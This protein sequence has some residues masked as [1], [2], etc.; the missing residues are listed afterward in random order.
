MSTGIETEGSPSQVLELELGDFIKIADRANENLNHQ[1]F[2]IDYIDDTQLFLINSDTFQ[3]VKITI[4]PDG[5]MN[6]GT[7]SKITILN[8]SD[9]K[10]YARQHDLLPKTWV[11]IHF[12]GDLPTIITGLI[13]N[14]EHDMIEVKTTYGDTIYINFDYK[15]IPLDLP[16]KLFEIRAEPQVTEMPE[17]NEPDVI[18]SEPTDKDFAP[19][20]DLAPVSPHFAPL[21]PKVDVRDQLREFIINADQIVFGERDLGTLYQYED[22][23]T[24]QQRYSIDAQVT[25]MLDEFLSNVPDAQ[26]TQKVL[27]NIHTMIE[28]FKQLREHF[29]R[30]DEYGNVEGAFTV[31]PMYK[32]LFEYFEKFQNNLYWILPVVK[33]TKKL[34]NT[35]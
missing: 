35:G 29:S 32:P 21:L 17:G 15:G 30:F 7:I 16:I 12:G 33:N 10:G 9:E 6:N 22:V 3:P 13:T 14:L 23:S 11:D 18:D 34:Y 20:G 1:V 8:R 5:T 24:K 26:R 2:Y 25:D 19:H 27:N 28:R 4:N 31:K